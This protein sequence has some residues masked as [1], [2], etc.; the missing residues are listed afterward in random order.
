MNN[1][2]HIFDQFAVIF[3]D[4]K[5]PD[6]ILSVTDIDTLCLHFR[7]VFV[8][9]DGAFSLARTVNPTENDT[10]TYIR[11]VSAAIQGNTAICCT[12]TPKVH[13]MLK[14]VP[15][16]M[17]N[18][19]GGLGDKMEDWVERLH[20]TGMRERQRFRTVQNPIIRALAR[21][22]A[23]SCNMHTNVLA[24][25]DKTNEGNKR[26]LVKTKVDRISMR[27]K[28]QQ[29]VGRQ[30]AM[31]YFDKESK[32]ELTWSALLFDN[33]KVGREHKNETSVGDS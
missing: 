12:I 8:L 33:E 23:V 2:S 3:K 22:K 17:R 11:Y 18:I 24:Q 7:E 25:V 14:H 10:L 4:G 5:R 20:Q 13:L 27:R 15:W 32:K 26:N 29:D 1:A 21:E 6:C 28:R 19:P 16:Q 9:W 31:E 30:E